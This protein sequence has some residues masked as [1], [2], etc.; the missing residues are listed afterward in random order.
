MNMSYT[1]TTADRHAVVAHD[2][3]IAARK[4]LLARERELTRLRDRIASDRRALPWER[5]IRITFSIRPKGQEHYQRCL[6]S[7]VN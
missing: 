3:W 4:Q 2:E 7:T 5:S 6:A 1:E